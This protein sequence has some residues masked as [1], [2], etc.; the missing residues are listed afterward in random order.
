MRLIV[1][2]TGASG[3]ALGVRM[4]E[5]LREFPEVETH[6][7]VSKW[8]RMTISWETGLSVQ[9]VVELADCKYH[10]H[11]QGAAVSSGSFQVDGM[12]VVPCSMK[13]LAGIRH[14]FG[15]DLICR[16]ADV[17]LKEQRKLVLVARET[18]LSPI[19]LENMYALAQI[20]AV[21]FPP[22]PAFYARP[23]SIDD[24]VEHLVVRV[25]DQFGLALAGAER[26][27]GWTTPAE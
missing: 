3:A 21:I 7:I 27:S 1:A 13:T 11:D 2:M 18:P 24:L 10:S 23:E 4:L 26:W 14:G 5:R 6:L 19:H 22:A 25:L 15:D 16:A 20:G 9:D 17:T 12:V 8:A